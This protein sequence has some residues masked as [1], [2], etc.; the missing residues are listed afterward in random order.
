MA[1][2]EKRHIERK[3]RGKNVMEMKENVMEMKKEEK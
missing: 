3:E 2:K 1:L